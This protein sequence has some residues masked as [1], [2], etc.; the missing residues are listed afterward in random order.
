MEGDEKRGPEMPRFTEDE[1]YAFAVA[2]AICLPILSVFAYFWVFEVD[3][4]TLRSAR[5]SLLTPLGTMFAGLITFA[6]VAWR[7]MVA[8]RQANEQRRQNDANETANYVSLLERGAK[9]LGSNDSLQDRLAGIALIDICLNEPQKRVAQEALDLLGHYIQDEWSVEAHKRSVE[10]ATRSLQNA[11]KVHGLEVAYGRLKVESFDASQMAALTS[12][13]RYEHIGTLRNWHWIRG[14]RRL[15]LFGGSM[16]G[17]EH[18]ETVINEIV[19]GRD[20]NSRRNLVRV[21]VVGGYVEIDYKLSKCLFVDC[22]IFKIRP[23]KSVYLA[24]QYFIHCDFS[25]VTFEGYDSLRVLL[26]RP[27]KDD[28]PYIIESFFYADDPPK[29]IERIL[30]T[31]KGEREIVETVEVEWDRYLLPV[32]RPIDKE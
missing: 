11:N 4:D 28:R 6:T 13:Q 23:V 7:G 24:N 18:P 8:S 30:P 2:M 12:Q 27:S 16:W 10:R 32:E 29:L 5:V 15:E 3:A 1:W 9:L 19:A 21:A 14:F 26:A 20:P 31:K 17:A 25:G 22:A